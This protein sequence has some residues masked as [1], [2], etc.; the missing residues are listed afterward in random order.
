MP[1]TPY[2]FGPGIFI[3]L[4]FIRFL[5]FPTF[6]IA[7]V[8]IDIEPFLVL[9]LHLN[10]PVHG[11]FHSLLG[12]SIIALI[13]AGI[14]ILIRKYLT[15]L[16]SFFK[17]EQKVS[18]KKIIFASLFSI[19]IHILL[20][21]TMYWDIKPLFPLD[22]NPFLRYTSNPGDLARMICE[23]CF[24]GGLGVYIVRVIVIVMKD[25]KNKYSSDD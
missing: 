12:G 1:Y 24:F 17:L 21:A 10:Y 14:M 25:R 11:F 2:H 20:D 22:F 13:L 7:S 9:S 15:P 5:D 19:Y 23:F 16:M 18:Y 8:I 6:L 3:G 4:V